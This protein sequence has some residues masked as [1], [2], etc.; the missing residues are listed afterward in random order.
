MPLP[1]FSRVLCSCRSPAGPLGPSEGLCPACLLEHSFGPDFAYEPPPIPLAQTRHRRCPRGG[2]PWLRAKVSCPLC[3][4]APCSRLGRSRCQAGC[5]LGC[6][7]PS[8]DL[9]V[10]TLVP[11]ALAQGPLNRGRS[12]K[13][14]ELYSAANRGQKGEAISQAKSILGNL[15]ALN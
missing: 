7:V 8:G 11:K 5:A 13:D 1:R 6:H 10:S 12:H 14:G 9:D 4:A 15:I 2:L 3:A